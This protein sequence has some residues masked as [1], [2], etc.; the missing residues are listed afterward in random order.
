[1]TRWAPH[2]AMRTKTLIAAGLTLLVVTVGGCGRKDAAPVEPADPQPATPAPQVDFTANVDVTDT[3][4]HITY[5]LTNTSGGE[6][7]AFNSDTVYVTGQ[8]NGRVQLAQRAFAMPDGSITWASPIPAPGVRVGDGK[9]ITGDL[10]VPLPLQRKHPY[11][12]DYGNGPIAL[13]DPITDVVFCL[14]VVRASDVTVTVP[15]GEAMTLPNL[16]STTAVQHLLCSAP[17]TLS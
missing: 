10:S 11:G 5:A 13:P 1:M 16:A 8:P 7:Y 15:A 3:A 17:A 6:L 4:V 12:N 9:T 2:T 14:G